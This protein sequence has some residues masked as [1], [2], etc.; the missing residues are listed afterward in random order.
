MDPF[1]V[2]LWIARLAF[3][4]MLYVVLFAI[5]RVL[6]RDLRRAA[7]EPGLELGRLVVVASPTGD[8]PVGAAFPLDA[9]TR[10]GR[11]VNNTVVVDDPYAS[12]EHALLSFR[13]RAW[14]LEDLGST[15]GTLLDGARVD[16]VVPVGFG[17]E[18]TV[19]ETKLRLDRGRAPA[20]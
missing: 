11:D 16:D 20:R 17:D 8:P 14:Y 3:L 2:G 5:V 10:I 18:I 4:G 13:G 12:A 19:G 9:V 7:L 1:F 6:L 15:N